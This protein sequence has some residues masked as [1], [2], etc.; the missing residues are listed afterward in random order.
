MDYG[1]AAWSTRSG[2]W[3]ERRHA[4][5]VVGEARGRAGVAVEHAIG[6]EH[7]SALHD[8]RKIGGSQLAIL[9]PGRHDHQRVGARLPRPSGSA[10]PVV[11]GATDGGHHR[12]VNRDGLPRRC[13]EQRERRA[14]SWSSA[15]FPCRQDQ[16]RRSLA[17]GFASKACSLK[18][19]PG[20]V[21][22]MRGIGKPRLRRCRRRC[23]RLRRCCMM[24]R[25]SRSRLPPAMPRPGAE[26]GVLPDALVEL[27]RRHDIRPVGA[28]LLAHLGKRIGDGDRRNE[29]EVDADLGELGAFVGH[30]KDRAG[31]RLQEGLQGVMQRLRADRRSR[32]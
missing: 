21:L 13:V 6:I 32:R 14:N 22:A 8:A 15:C 16:A 17:S 7:A 11:H 29:A 5:R 20:P 4:E 28:D 10:A 12:I 18:H 1:D 27:Q 25:R 19:L 2:R 30:R 3:R 26:I 31:E 24:V 23:F 9:R